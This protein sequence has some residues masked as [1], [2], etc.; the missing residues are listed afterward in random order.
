MGYMPRWGE[1][2]P[3]TDTVAR[4]T[5]A[6]DRAQKLKVFIAAGSGLAPFQPMFR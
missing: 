2:M 6:T 1:P 5:K 3:L 4:N